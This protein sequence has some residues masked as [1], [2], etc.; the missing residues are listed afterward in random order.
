MSIVICYSHADA[1]FAD[2]I[3]TALVAAKNNVWLDK[4]ELRV[5]DSLVDRIQA[6]IAKAGALLIIL[7][8]S[9]V[10]SDWCKRELKA[11]YVR[12]FDTKGFTILPVLKE[13]CEIP[14][15]LQDKQ[16]ANF[17]DSPEDGLKQLL[18]S[19]ARFSSDVLG[20]IT[21]SDYNVDWSIDWATIG[22]DEGQRMLRVTIAEHTKHQPYTCLT[23]LTILPNDVATKRAEGYEALGMH[24]F[25]RAVFLTFVSAAITDM[26]MRL[27]DQFAQEQDFTVSDPKTGVLFDCLISSRRLGADTGMDILIHPGA[28]LVTITESLMQTVKAEAKESLDASAVVL[29]ESSPGKGNRAERRSAA[30]AKKKKSGAKTTKSP[31]TT[32]PKN[33]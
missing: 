33:K 11:A 3:A 25:G 30:K 23:E 10:T 17:V 24:E 29:K 7:S 13:K 5:G 22:D 14:L 9:S 20:R 15:F 18:E 2:S 32:P 16:Y 21:D 19:V 31:K 26:T 1:E 4:W 12:E 27:T 8:K 28:Q 6:A